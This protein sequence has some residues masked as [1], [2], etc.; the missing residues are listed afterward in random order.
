MDDF[1]K[2]MDDVRINQNGGATKPDSLPLT[3]PVEQK[4]EKLLAEIENLK[5]LVKDLEAKNQKLENVVLGLGSLIL[6]KN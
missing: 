2:Y 4:P 6:K 5:I 3:G 1:H